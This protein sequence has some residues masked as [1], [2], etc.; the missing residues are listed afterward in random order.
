MRVGTS[1]F[2]ICRAVSSFAVCRRGA[3]SYLFCCRCFA[4]TSCAGWQQPRAATEGKRERS[5]QGV[6]DTAAGKPPRLR[7]GARCALQAISCGYP[8]L[9][10]KPAWKPEL[11]YGICFVSIRV[12][13]D[14][15]DDPSPPGRPAECGPA[16]RGASTLITPAGRR[17]C[18]SS[19]AGR[20]ATIAGGHGRPALSLL[21][22]NYLHDMC[23]V[24]NVLGGCRFPAAVMRA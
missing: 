15:P 18:T 21:R 8:Q 6:V 24:S 22:E 16:V 12:R 17:C 3:G 7:Q 11:E 19:K 13:I 20:S 10:F 4:C 1:D 9:F 5:S 23:P 14:H 2:R